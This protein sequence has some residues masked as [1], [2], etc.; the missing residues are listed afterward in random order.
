MLDNKLSQVL[1]TEIDQKNR[2]LEQ[3]E[4]E[5]AEPQRSREVCTTAVVFA[6]GVCSLCRLGLACDLK[7]ERIR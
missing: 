1:P 3:L 5:A 2:K 6:R 4:R 7:G